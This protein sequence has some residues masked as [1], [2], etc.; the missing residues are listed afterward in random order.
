MFKC[1]MHS[2]WTDFDSQTLTMHFFVVV[3]V[4]FHIC[5]PTFVNNLQKFASYPSFDICVKRWCKITNIPLS[6]SFLLSLLIVVRGLLI[7]KLMF[8][9]CPVQSFLVGRSCSIKYFLV[10]WQKGQS[11]LNTER[12]VFNDR[13]GMV[14]WN[15]DIVD[16]MVGLGY[17]TEEF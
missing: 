7:L 14:A 3:Y 15:I 2:V 11:S 9:T 17:I 8:I 13:W 16:D 6:Y 4:C 1:P 5:L 10:R 12:N